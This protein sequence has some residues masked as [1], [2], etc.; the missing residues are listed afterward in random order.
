MTQ[1]N[2][3]TSLGMVVNYFHNECSE[4]H[5]KLLLTTTKLS[6]RLLKMNP[7]VNTVVLVDGSKKPDT[8]MREFCLKNEIKY[9]HSGKQIGYAA[10]YN[11]GWKMLDESY[12]GLMANDIIPHPL[13]TIQTLL[14]WIKK[15]DI[16]CVAPYFHTNRLYYD[17]VQRMGYW[18]RSLQTCEPASITLNL[19]LFKRSVL[20]KIDGIDESYMYGY[21]EPIFIIKIRS[22]GYRVVLVGGTQSF[23][24][25]ELTKS[26]GASDLKYT[27]YKMDTQ[28]WLKEY[29]PYASKRGIANIKLW[30]WP[31]STT[32][33]TKVLWWICYCCPIIRLRK[34]LLETVM[35]IE[36]F[37]THYP[38]RYGKICTK[39][40]GRA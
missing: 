16:G 28:K 34:K 3:K 29:A 1:L 23:H 8:D 31:F 40:K 11:L 2:P 18:N 38:A 9:C 22:L 14:D 4:E 27:Q 12:I 30:K 39:D 33:S 36:P 5:H 19:N 25:G 10:A 37:L 32:L 20:E 13:E 6:L 26:L 21:T 35:W 15:A 7:C 17:E 24:Y